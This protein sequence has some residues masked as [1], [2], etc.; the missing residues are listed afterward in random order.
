MSSLK[1]VN[2][3]KRL[4][5]D[6][7]NIIKNPLTEQGIYYIHDETDMYHGTAMIIGPEDTPYAD[8]FYL[9]SLRFSTEYPFQPP[10]VT[11]C[12]NDGH[13]RFNPNLYRC[14]K[15][16]ISILNTWKGEQWTSCQN[17]R[18]VLLTIVSLLNNNPLTNEPGFGPNHRSCK[19]Y[20]RIIEYRNFKT[21]ILGMLTKKYL[22]NEFYSY[23][24]I[25][26]NE[27]LKRKDKILERIQKLAIEDKYKSDYVQEFDMYATYKYCKLLEKMKY[28][29]DKLE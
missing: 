25:I 18:S 23:H 13:T 14:G 17:I 27:I 4:L 7:K 29:I 15:V 22:P 20:R 3:T 24:S 9:F 21:A 11:Y 6:V 12:T 19:P 5:K 8:G 1:C 2:N 26:C 28:A 10:K 16:C